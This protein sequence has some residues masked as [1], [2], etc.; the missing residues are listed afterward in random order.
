MGKW[1]NKKPATRSRKK[2]KL[3][4]KEIITHQKVKGMVEDFCIKLKRNNPYSH[5]V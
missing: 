5:P 4:L 2:K 1:T 3:E